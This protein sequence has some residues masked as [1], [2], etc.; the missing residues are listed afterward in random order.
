MRIA[1]YGNTL[2]RQALA[3]RRFCAATADFA[4][5]PA[6]WIALEVQSG[7]EALPGAAGVRNPHHSSDVHAIRF[8]DTHRFDVHR[9]IS[10]LA[11][12][13]TTCRLR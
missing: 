5:M 7:V 6:S 8:A 2:D 3:R 10:R 13:A 11:S 1:A 9:L 4:S 12:P